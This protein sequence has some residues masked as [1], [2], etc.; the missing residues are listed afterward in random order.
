VKPV[1]KQALRDTVGRRVAEL[2]LARGMTQESFAEATGF[3][4]RYIQTIE[5]GEANLTL[6]SL[7]RL[8]TALRAPVGDLFHAP[9]R[10]RGRAKRRPAR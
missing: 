1:D 3:Y 8:A 2:R 5:A 6:D 10:A 9:S 4:A 7:A